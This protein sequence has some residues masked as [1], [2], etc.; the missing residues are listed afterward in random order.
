[1]RFRIPGSL[2]LIV[3]SLT[4][5]GAGHLS[6]ESATA[7]TR[8]AATTG[9]D[10]ASGT[11]TAPY[12]TAQKLASSL[13]AGEVGCLEPGTYEENLR[14]GRGGAPGNPITITSTPGGPRATVR[15][16]LVVVDS[17]NDVTIADLVLD[18]RSATGQ[19]SPAVNGDRVTFSGNEVTNFN[20]GICF[21][22]GDPVFGRALDDVIDGNRI[23]GCG[24]IPSTNLHHG[25]Y[26]DEADGLRITNNYIYDNAD[27]GVQL[28]PN[29]QGTLVAG[30]VIDGNGEGVIFGGAAGSASSNNTVR[31]NIITNSSI[32]HNVESSW[33]GPVGTGN[34]LV[35]NCVFGGRSGN[36]QSPQVGFSA[37][38]TIVADPLYVNRAAKDFTLR[39]GSPCAGLG[40]AFVPAPPGAPAG[41]VGVP[42]APGPVGGSPGQPSASPSGRARSSRLVHFVFHGVLRGKATR[43]G[44]RLRVRSANRYGRRALAGTRTVSLRLDRASVLRKGTGHRARP[45]TLRAG[46][47][48]VAR[49]RAPLGTPAASLP[50]LR[51]LV[52]LGPRR[53]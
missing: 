21:I 25:I 9:N 8:Y 16:R 44:I 41:V 46:D 22:V 17:A 48:V 39:S 28:Y 13:T 23:H 12:R 3:G 53:R 24:Q 43:A 42:A 40:P 11:A 37:S 51:L 36:V 19:P 31:D 14:V 4:A 26:V 1:M 20:T 27:R 5:L 7:C 32:R 52:D 6:A 50:A 29:A 49:V 10:A 18:G 34:V 15:G 38:G 30:N 45:A 35:H 33:P 2:S 47:R